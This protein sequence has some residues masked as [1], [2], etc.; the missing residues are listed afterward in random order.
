MKEEEKM[1]AEGKVMKIKNVI[2][3]EGDLVMIFDEAG[4]QVT[5]YQGTYEDVKKNILKDAPPDAIFAHWF[6]RD[7]KPE[8]VLREEW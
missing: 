7:V 1:K 8:T 6:E 5:E 4:E 2:R 3:D